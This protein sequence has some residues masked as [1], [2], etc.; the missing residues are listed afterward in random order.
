[1]FK[2]GEE[3]ES[4]GAD[5]DGSRDQIAEGLRNAG[6]DAELAR[7]ILIAPASGNFTGVVRGRRV[8]RET[9]R[10]YV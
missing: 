5:R 9:P 8:R 10:G 4:M 2:V 3:D 7:T 6:D 1:M